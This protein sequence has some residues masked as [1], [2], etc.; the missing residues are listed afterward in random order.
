M[1]IC[2]ILLNI[3]PR[4]FLA[5]TRTYYEMARQPSLWHARR[6]FYLYHQNIIQY[7]G[8]F[9][10]GLLLGYAIIVRDNIGD[11]SDPKS[12]EKRERKMI[13]CNVSAMVGLIMPFVW[14]N[15]FFVEQG[16]SHNELSILLFFSIGRLMFGLSFGWIIY[17]SVDEKK[18]RE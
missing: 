15:Q 11:D 13:V 14:V 8:S 9:S 6:S 12:S 1:I 18:S 17:A 2:S 7:L 16:V 5:N 3:S 10:I 4:L